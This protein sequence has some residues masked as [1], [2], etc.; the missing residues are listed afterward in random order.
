MVKQE[1]VDENQAA[2]GIVKQE[3]SE[4]KPESHVPGDD[5]EVAADE[6]SPR[7]S[8]MHPLPDSDPRLLGLVELPDG[9]RKPVWMVMGKD[10]SPNIYLGDESGEPTVVS[11]EATAMGPASEPTPAAQDTSSWPHNFR[12]ASA[13]VDRPDWLPDG[14]IYGTNPA[15]KSDRHGKDRKAF[16]HDCG[17]KKVYCNPGEV[18]RH[19]RRCNLVAA[20][21]AGA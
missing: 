11:S 17:C 19:H 6:T 1:Q 20:A 14:W 5:A 12:P 9:T 7:F 18:L 13:D 15:V 4:L 8:S 10:E 16:L 21:D 3:Q 2:G